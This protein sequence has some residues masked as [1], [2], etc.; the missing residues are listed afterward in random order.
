MAYA[1]IVLFLL[2]VAYGLSRRSK[3]TKKPLEYIRTL[4]PE[5][6]TLPLI[7]TRQVQ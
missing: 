3:V 1:L 5:G 7:F 4:W 2:V 6:R